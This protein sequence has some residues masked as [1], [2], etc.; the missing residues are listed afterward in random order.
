MHQHLHS[1]RI[2][3]LGLAALCLS[4][5]ETLPNQPSPPVQDS[6]SDA[7]REVEV[8]QSEAEVRQSP[9]TD[10]AT[11]SLRLAAN[12]ASQQGDHVGAISYLERA[13]RIDPRNARLWTSLAAEHLAKGDLRAASQHARKAIALAAGDSE[14]TRAA[15]LQLADVRAAEGKVEEAASIRQRYS[16]GRG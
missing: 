6:S 4:A 10:Q 14:R 3:L 5:C 2:L 12:T 13:V 7:P 16:T 9:N 15:W 1:F 8:E 11:E